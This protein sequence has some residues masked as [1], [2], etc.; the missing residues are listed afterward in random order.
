MRRKF[1]QSS[2]RPLTPR[3]KRIRNR[4]GFLFVVAALT[5]IV[6]GVYYNKLEVK[7]QRVNSDIVFFDSLYNDAD[8]IPESSLREKFT[9]VFEDANRLREMNDALFELTSSNARYEMALEYYADPLMHQEYR[10]RTHTNFKS[11]YT[12]EQRK[13]IVKKIQD[14]VKSFNPIIAY[15]DAFDWYREI[16]PVAIKEIELFLFFTE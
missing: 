5:S 7:Q 8:Y 2:G 10:D 14:E 1:N 11:K 6:L 13:E 12:Q 16:D 3:E 9:R 15:R 4:Y